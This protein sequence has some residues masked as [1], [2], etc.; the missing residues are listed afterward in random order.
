MSKKKR[1][2]DQKSPFL[3]STPPLT[4]SDVSQLAVRWPCSTGD[5]VDNTWFV[6]ALTAGSAR[7]WQI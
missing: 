4:I 2:I 7:H 5:S 6:A 3:Q 1:D